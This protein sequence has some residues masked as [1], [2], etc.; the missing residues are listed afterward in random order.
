MLVGLVGATSLGIGAPIADDEMPPVLT[1]VARLRPRPSP[2]EPRFG[3]SVAI[4]GT[5][6]LVGS[7]IDAD[8]STAGGSVHLFR[9]GKGGWRRM[10]RIQFEDGKPEDRF[11]H[12][13]AADGTWLLVGRDR[14]DEAGPDAG[15]IAI[16]RRVGAHYRFET[17]IAP[18]VPNTYAGFGQS[19]ALGGSTLAIGAPRDDD[20]GLDSGSVEIFAF[21]DERWSRET[22][23]VAGDGAAG[24]WFGFAVAAADDLVV[25][26]SYGDDDHGPS[27]GSAHLFRR[28]EGSWSHE[29]KLVPAELKAG[30]WFGFAVAAARGLVAVGAPRD[31]LA[32]ESAGSVRIY[33]ARRDGW[34]P[35]GE[36][37]PP[38]G[39]VTSW[40]GYA[41][42]IDR[43]ESVERMLIG[44]PGDDGEIHNGGA[45]YLY[46]RSTARND[47][48]WRLRLVLRPSEPEQDG[49]FGSSVAIRGDLAVV[50]R[51]PNED[52]K[53]VPGSA[54]VYRLDRPSR[55]PS[56][57]G[58]S[59][60]G[61]VSP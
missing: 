45:A 5:A 6:V 27:S 39:S 32:G 13:I 10:Q 14:A 30:D 52:G 59:P 49:L 22:K 21:R 42:A 41:I 19:V 48:V 4:G 34:S 61:S 33:R 38:L 3:I 56:T 1:E 11:G 2:V 54:W 46:E 16:F 26:G 17:T 58:A 47:A 37:R 55:P 50:G 12:A 51:Y 9:D 23:L 18:S 36:L 60:S 7:P 29:L 43:T 44:A 57:A 20:A 15:G 53:P 40:F 28:R 31:D 8:P 24:D 25:V 35:D